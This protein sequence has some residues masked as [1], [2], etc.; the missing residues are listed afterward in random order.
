M[1]VFNLP[2]DIF[3][4]K[5]ALDSSI[6]IHHYCSNSGNFKEKSIL[7]RN[8]IS[9]VISGQKTM[10]FLEKAVYTNDK[11]IHFLSAGNCIASMD[12]SMQ[13]V[14][15]SILIF[16]DNKELVEFYVANASFIDK[17]KK[18]C[19]SGESGYISFNKD[20]Y[21]VN[22]INSLQLTLSKNGQLSEKMKRLKLQELL[23]YLLENHT[24]TFLS[25]RNPDTISQTE[26]T[27][28]K[29]VDANVLSKLTIDDMAFLCN[30]ST[31]SFKRYFNK[32]FNASP[33]AW[34]LERKMSI[35]AQ[36]LKA[37]KEK[38]GEIWFKL[39]FETHTGFTKA[40]KKQFGQSPTA[41][42]NS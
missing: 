15:E 22:Y 33:N 11:E 14:F 19:T 31:S 13:N 1:K 36:M 37:N 39:G 26:L 25:F 38:P 7:H 8:A 24:E 32:I 28:R 3:L 17:F 2:D 27:I 12:T 23:L 18:N 41:Y 6:I 34:L 40:F 30:L 20:N 21:I 9:L 5:T 29:V 42:F 10:N 4:D 16:F 35:A